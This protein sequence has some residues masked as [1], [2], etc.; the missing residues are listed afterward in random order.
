MTVENMLDLVYGIPDS[1]PPLI[2]ASYMCVH[3]GCLGNLLN[4]LL[5]SLTGKCNSR[6]NRHA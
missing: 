1:C 4:K 3:Y 2:A 6:N 5:Y